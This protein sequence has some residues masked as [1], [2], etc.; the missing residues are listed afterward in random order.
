M[1]KHQ[2]VAGLSPSN[3]VFDKEALLDATYLDGIHR[4]ELS[5]HEHYAEILAVLAESIDRE[6]NGFR[7]IKTNDEGQQ[8][9]I[10]SGTHNSAES[11]PLHQLVSN[12]S[13]TSQIMEHCHQYLGDNRAWRNGWNPKSY[14]RHAKACHKAQADNGVVWGAFSSL[15]ERS[16]KLSK[17]ADKLAALEAKQAKRAA[18]QA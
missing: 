6:D 11:D 13:G 18:K 3:L 1:Y 17:V 14:Q 15:S 5:A 9:I 7:N 2:S 16:K 8:S 10:E 12:D 4:H